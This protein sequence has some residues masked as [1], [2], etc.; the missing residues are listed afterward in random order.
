[1]SYTFR[2]AP[3][4]AC[5]TFL[6]TSA[7]PA[8]YGSPA[9]PGA[10]D[11]P[12][13]FTEV[14]AASGLVAE[15][16]PHPLWIGP[17]YWM[18]GG[19]AVGDFDRDKHM[20]VFVLSGGIGRDLLFLGDG[21]GAFTEHGLEWGLTHVHAGVGV[22]AADYDGD[23]WLDLYVTSFGSRQNAGPG[24]HLLYK[25]TGEGSFKNVAREAGVSVTSR[26][27]AG[28]YSPAFGDYDL[29]G[30]LDLFVAIWQNGTGGNRLFRNEGDG[31][32]VDVTDAALG[33]T[34]DGVRG[35]TP[36][37]HDM[38]G[39]Q[40]PEL[41]IAA[42][43]ETSRYLVNQGGTSFVDRTLLSGTGL[44]DNGMGATVG[45]FDNDGL[46]DWYVT[47]IHYDEAPPGLNPGNM[48]YVNGGA[49]VLSELSVPLGVNDGGWGWGTHAAD[50]DHDGWLELVEVNGGL[51]KPWFQEGGK[52]FH[53]N[54]P[55][56]PAG[57]RAGATS[58]TE[59]AFACGFSTAGEGRGVITFDPDED[60]DL[61]LAV[62]SN[63]EPVELF[64]NDSEDLGSWLRVELETSAN[65]KLA[66]HGFQSRVL[67]T[68]GET[69]ISRYVDGRP[70]YLSCGEL[71]LHFGLGDATTVDVLRVEWPRGYVTE[72]RDVAVDR[73][74]RIQ[75]PVLG[76]LDG[77]GQL[78]IE[79]LSDL[80][81]R[82][83]PIR[84]ATD[85][86]ADLTGN[87]TV[88]AEDAR[89]WLAEY[90]A[91]KALARVIHEDVR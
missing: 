58:F 6:V 77:S 76:D 4:V 39:D 44:D 63:S 12:L 50:L 40:Y 59:M 48:L 42:D 7:T 43:F 84:R 3:L 72:L 27:H 82:Q 57:R 30:D 36:V 29:D 78:G 17:Q 53:N 33:T 15:S 5:A 31:T 22:A 21:A 41:L 49:H 11:P 13:Q 88:D 51:H 8:T 89:L 47:S 81:A 86:K 38:D 64:R 54:G 83:G 1:M 28:G 32:F 46:D 65:P 67:A 52:L 75:A 61:D 60:G 2:I 16:R 14:A 34:V 80:L 10:S 73:T 68:V 91:A 45:D 90:R 20:D 85:L 69:T 87:G 74:I 9:L 24:Q 55:S 62:F 56:S 25:N 66:P 70:S 37:F 23:G 26:T 18:T 19:L 71:A 35:F 79:D